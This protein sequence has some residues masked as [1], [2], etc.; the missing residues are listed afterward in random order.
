M[1][2]FKK[3]PMEFK[4]LKSR[5]IYPMWTFARV[6]NTDK[7]YLILGRSKLEFISERAFESWN[8]RCILISEEAVVDYP[9]YK[10]VGFAVG[11]IVVSEADSTAWYITGSDILTPERCLIA[12]PDFYEKLGFSGDDAVRVS[13]PELDFHKKGKN[14][15][16]VQ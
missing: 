4:P 6:E 12:T 15:E 11:T 13:L 1:S 9:R 2:W 5:L 3:P 8:R 7:Y 16:V 14:I 10:Q